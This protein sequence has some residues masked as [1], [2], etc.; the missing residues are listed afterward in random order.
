VQASFIRSLP[1]GFV[2]FLLT[3]LAIRRKRSQRSQAIA[4]FPVFAQAEGLQHQQRRA[5]EIGV[6]TGQYRGFELRVD[7]DEGAKIW[8]RFANHPKLEL[9]SFKFFKRQPVGMVP[10]L[11]EFGEFEGYFVERFASEGIN[12]AL[13]EREAD[14]LDQI[15]QSLKASP[16]RIL[17]LSVSA[18]GI[19]CRL[20]AERVSYIAKATLEYLLPQLVRL[21]KVLDISVPQP[22]DDGLAQDQPLASDGSLVSN[23]SSSAAKS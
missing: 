14:D 13:L 11:T 6:L 15:V 21:A 12:E 9:R 22:P 20:E 7:P 4:D 18:E 23:R 19:E 17:A 3:Y 10:L 2:L 5:G 16:Q 1:I 8:V